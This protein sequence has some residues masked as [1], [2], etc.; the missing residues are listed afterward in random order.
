MPVAMHDDNPVGKWLEPAD[1]PLAVDERR[2]DALGQSHAGSRVL[3]DM[4]MDAHNPAGTGILRKGG[5]DG[6]ELVGGH[7]SERI[8]EREMGI[9]I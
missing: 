5:V 2:P 7:H 3:D 4:M 9:G 1:E 6:R 8:G